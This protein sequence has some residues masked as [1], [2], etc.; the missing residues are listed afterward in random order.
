VTPLITRPSGKL[1]PDLL[2]LKGGPHAFVE[3]SATA[4]HQLPYY[5]VMC[6]A[7]PAGA[8]QRRGRASLLRP[9]HTFVSSHV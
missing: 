5:L 9:E 6:S 2:N 1:T 8:G 7:P 4:R 3:S